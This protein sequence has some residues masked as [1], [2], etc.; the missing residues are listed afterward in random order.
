MMAEVRAEEISA[1]AGNP[2]R[3]MGQSRPPSREA[4]SREL[5]R[6]PIRESGLTMAQ[7]TSQKMVLGLYDYQCL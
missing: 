7:C 4:L 1:E 2:R 5:R 3:Y 6:A